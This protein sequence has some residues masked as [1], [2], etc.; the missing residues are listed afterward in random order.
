MPNYRP[1]TDAEFR[2]LMERVDELRARRAV[3]EVAPPAGAPVAESAEPEQPVELHKL[4]TE[5]FRQHAAETFNRATENF[6]SPAWRPRQPMT[7]SQF[8]AA[9]RGEA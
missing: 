3:T 7:L 9:G 2:A 8:L 5:E 1:A 6:N 4:S